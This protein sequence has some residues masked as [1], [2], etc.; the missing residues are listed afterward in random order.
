MEMRAV[1]LAGQSIWQ[2]LARSGTGIGRVFLLLLCA[3]GWSLAGG[4]APPL[5]WPTGLSEKEI[6][7]LQRA[8]SPRAHVEAVLKIS[9]QRMSEA[10][11]LARVNRYQEAREQLSLFVSLIGYA[12]QYTRALP[13][14]R[15]KDRDQ[16]LK[17]L[18]QAIFRQ[19]NPLD[20]LLSDFP[21]QLREES[22][23]GVDQVR[24]IRL[25]AIN[26]LLGG[27]RAINPPE[28]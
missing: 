1:E 19:N 18:E 12:D 25:R 15:R 8:T 26:D 27:G 7:T 9:A 20:T 13:P 11:S 17:R 23:P 3:T 14:A 24:R 10:L 5:T 28:E 2:G 21:Y 16:N 22:Q 6:A 4:Q